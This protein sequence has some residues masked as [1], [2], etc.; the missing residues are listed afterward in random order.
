MHSE[1]GCLGSDLAHTEIEYRIGPDHLQSYPQPLL[2]RDRK[3]RINS[4]NDKSAASS[5]FPIV[6]ELEI[7]AA[8][9]STS[10]RKIS[11]AKA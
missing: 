7:S 2:Q 8:K 10:L 4:A 6:I 5:D 11:A 3:S 9:A 1:E